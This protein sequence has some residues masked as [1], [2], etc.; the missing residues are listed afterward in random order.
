M[1]LDKI[2]RGRQWVREDHKD[3]EVIRMKL[4]RWLVEQANHPGK[5]PLLIL[6][7]YVWVADDTP[8]AFTLF[9][10]D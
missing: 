1:R 6:G 4:G 10:G 9:E 7:D 8:A 3:T 5:S 2:Q